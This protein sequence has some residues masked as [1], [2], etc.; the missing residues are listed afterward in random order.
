MLC[1]AKT[2]SGGTCKR[3]AMPN[4]RCNLHGGKSPKGIESPS[5]KHGR[6]SKYLPS[7][8]A[9]RYTEAQQDPALLELRAEIALIDTRL[10]D[11]LERL[12]KGESGAL[13]T[14]IASEFDK[15]KKAQVVK[16]TDEARSA[17]SALDSL[18]TEGIGDYAAWKEVSELV[19][20]RR[21]LVES[22]RKHEVETQQMLSTEQALSLIGSIHETIRRHVA[23]S[24]ARQLIAADLARLV[25]DAPGASGGG[26]RG[27]RDSEPAPS[28]SV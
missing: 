18:F 17:L 21:K 20:Q 15:F 2:R 22:E 8:L 12:D 24:A 3:A 14:L 16:D 11:V 19:E 6:Y 10:T 26:G 23:D 4:G 1:G 27:A 9:A 25:G 7:R 5:F 28:D 13:W